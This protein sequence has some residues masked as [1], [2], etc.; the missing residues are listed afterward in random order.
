MGI[1]NRSTQHSHLKGG[2]SRHCGG[3]HSHR[4]LSQIDFGRLSEWHGRLCGGEAAPP[5]REV[6]TGSRS[7]TS[8]LSARTI[9]PIGYCGVRSIMGVKER[10]TPPPPKMSKEKTTKVDGAWEEKYLV[11]FCQSDPPPPLSLWTP[12]PPSSK[13]A[14]G[15]AVGGTKTFN[16]LTKFSTPTP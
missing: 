7:H 6:D 11:R 14:Y 9:I 10:N 15:T 12:P 5:V 13:R 4:A 16:M 3:R 8:T 1:L 2:C